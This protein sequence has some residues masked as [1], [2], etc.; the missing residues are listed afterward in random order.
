MIIFILTISE[1][2]WN[3]SSKSSERASIGI[4]AFLFSSISKIYNLNLIGHILMIKLCT[5]LKLLIFDSSI[6]EE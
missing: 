5:I 2:I 3:H 1:K 6:C 4:D